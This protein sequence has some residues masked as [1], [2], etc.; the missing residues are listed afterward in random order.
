MVMKQFVLI[1]ILTGAL[2]SCVRKTGN[3][4]M[5]IK[6]LD[7]EMINDD[8]LNRYIDKLDFTIVDTTLLYFS[9]IDKIIVDDSLLIN[10]VG[11]ER[12]VIVIVDKGGH[13]YG[14]IDYLGGGP[15]EYKQITDYTFNFKTKEIIV[16]DM[17]TRGLYSYNLRGQFKWQKK[18]DLGAVNL[19]TDDQY[20]Y[21][22]TKKFISELGSGNEVVVL[23]QNFKLVNSFFKYTEQPDRFRY[24]AD[25]VFARNDRNEILFSNVFRDTTYKISSKAC[26][27]YCTYRVNEEIPTRYTVDRDL[28]NNYFRKY[29]FYS[30]LYESTQNWIYLRVVQK[31]FFK[32]FYLSIDRKFFIETA[33]THIS[34]NIYLSKPIG[35]DNQ[36]FYYAIHPG[37][38]E[39]H[40]DEFYKLLTKYNRPDLVSYFDR[41]L[42]NYNPIIVRV[43]F[44]D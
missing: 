31:S 11:R 39:D 3:S 26:V 5:E 19:I 27:P 40:V 37:W 9:Q 43:K 6:I 4:K 18:L 28:F 34:K 36:Y 2:I 20:Y 8:G 41:N 33:N 38:I 22:Y 17:A 1:M 12:K 25:Q 44:I 35:C 29:N 42:L 30:G 23:D 15:G 13:L 16:Y 32:D 21:F 24:S 14:K 7:A 10:L